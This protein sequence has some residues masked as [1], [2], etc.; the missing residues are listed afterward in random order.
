M[1]EAITVVHHKRKALL[2]Y[3]S[4]EQ[5]FDDVCSALPGDI[6]VHIRVNRYPS[7]GV[8]RRLIDTILAARQQGSVNHVTG[9]VHYLTYFLDA[10][11]TVLT[12]LD[13]VTLERLRGLRRWVFWLF[14]YWLPEKRCAAI[15]VISESTKQQLLRYLSCDPDKITVIHCPVS[16]EFTASEKPFD[17]QCPRI[18]QV[19]TTENKNIGRVAE[20]LHGLPCRLAIIGP[21]SEVQK[22]VLARYAIDYENHVGL[23]R[24]ALVEQYRQADLVM[25]ASLYEGFGLPIVEANAVGRAVITSRLYSMPEVGGDAACYVDPYD[26][27]EI[28]SA[29]ERL[30]QDVAYRQELVTSGYKNVERFRPAAIARQYALLYRT[31]ARA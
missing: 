23:S 17:D 10:K 22:G 1:A 14:W 12:I 6:R 16:S 13:C 30:I 18:L 7:W 5:V 19:G 31:L 4:V 11:R 24:E 21:L 27:A 9:D 20:A 15:T 8:W 25:F 26:V 3:F 2:G 29:V 28:R